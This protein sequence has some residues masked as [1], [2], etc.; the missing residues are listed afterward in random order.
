MIENVKCSSSFYMET[1]SGIIDGCD[2]GTN[3]RSFGGDLGSINNG[4][5]KNCTAAGNGSFGQQGADGVTENCT[6]GLY[7]FASNL[8]AKLYGVRLAAFMGHI[9]IALLVSNPFSLEIL[10]KM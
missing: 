10:I 3:S 6:A 4:T 7:A 5:I 9:K 1:N 2:G 8:K